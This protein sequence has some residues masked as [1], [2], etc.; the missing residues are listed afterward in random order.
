M[1]SRR[2]G[3]PVRSTRVPAGRRA[4]VASNMVAT[5]EAHRAPTRWT[6]PGTLFGSINTS[7]RRARCAARTAGAA[8]KPPMLTTASAPSMSGRQDRA[9][10][11][12]RATARSVASETRDWAAAT[13]SPTN[14]N[15]A[16]GTNRASWPSIEPM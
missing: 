16:A 9:P 1:I 6:T 5:T 12:A 14:G 3:F 4:P 2:I 11:S 10:R 13:R 15:P 8:A 7:G